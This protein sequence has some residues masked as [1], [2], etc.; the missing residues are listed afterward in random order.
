MGRKNLGTCSANSNASNH[1]PFGASIRRVLYSFLQSNES[2]RHGFGIHG[3]ATLS[4]VYAPCRTYGLTLLSPD[5][6]VFAVTQFLSTKFSLAS[7]L[8][9]AAIHLSL[10][11]LYSRFSRPN[12]IGYYKILL[13]VRGLFSIGTYR[14]LRFISG[15]MN[16]EPFSVIG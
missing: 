6:C 9:R 15:F 1:A 12:S 5:V 8:S 3:N 10:C 2:S 14:K 7:L 11:D 4:H 13:C 16:L